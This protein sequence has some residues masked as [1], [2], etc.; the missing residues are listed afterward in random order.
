[1][2]SGSSSIW[3]HLRAVS[4]LPAMVAVAMPAVLLVMT[5]DIHV[6]W[7]LPRPLAALTLGLG[8]ALIAGGLAMFAWTVGLFATRGRGT[9]APWDPTERLVVEGP[10]RHVRN[11]MIS[12][13][14]AVLL[15]EAWLTG[16]RTI[17][18]WA[19]LFFLANAVYLPLS[20]EPGLERRFG[21][22]YRAYKRHVP[23][24]LPRVRPWRPETEVNQ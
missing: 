19:G 10:Y 24:W 2:E 16:S 23:R 13:V 20:E 4:L 18:A 14:L 5:R 3:R 11:P 21:E 7:G 9:L 8:G 22:A 1:M 12:G 6:G 15:G 17:A